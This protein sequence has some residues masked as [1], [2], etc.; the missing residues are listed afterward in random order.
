MSIKEADFVLLGFLLYRPMTGYELKAVMD[1]TTGH[2]YRPSYGGIYPGLGRL[3]RDG[4]AEM[5]MAPVGGR[6]KK[7]YRALP[8]G[9]KAFLAW[10]QIA[11]DITRGPG[12]VLA[13]MFF[14]G[15]GGREIAQSNIEEIVRR[16]QERIAW[17]ETVGE[18]MPAEAD[19]F[20]RA[21]REFGIEYYQFLKKWFE[22]LGR[23]K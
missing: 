6:A 23:R 20:Q 17:L 21:T 7:T 13:K 16:A 9:R 14:W 3:A 4:L 2:F 1:R 19:A 22:R 12:I 11:P 10:L 8:A 18:E 5:T 15:T